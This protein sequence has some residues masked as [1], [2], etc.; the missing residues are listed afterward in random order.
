MAWKVKKK[1]SNN[2][3][4]EYTESNQLKTHTECYNMFYVHTFL[5]ILYRFG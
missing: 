1:W 4:Y 3:R 5:H 2:Q